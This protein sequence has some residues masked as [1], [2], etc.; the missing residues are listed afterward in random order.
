MPCKRKFRCAQVKATYL[1]PPFHQKT[2]QVLVG[3]Y[4]WCRKQAAANWR[5]LRWWEI[6]FLEQKKAMS[7]KPQT[8][9]HLTQ[10]KTPKSAQN[11]T[12]SQTS[13]FPPCIYQRLGSVQTQAKQ[14]TVFASYIFLKWTWKTKF[15]LQTHFSVTEG[16]LS[17]KC[18]TR[19]RRF[20][21]QLTPGRRFHMGP[22]QAHFAFGLSV[23]TWLA[24]KS[25][26]SSHDSF[27]WVL[28]PPLQLIWEVLWTMF[29][30]H[31]PVARSCIQIQIK[32]ISPADHLNH[33]HTRSVSIS[34]SWSDVPAGW[35]G[36]PRVKQ[37]TKTDPSRARTFIRNKHRLC[38]R[39][40]KDL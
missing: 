40:Q 19:N 2:Q 39:F 25:W 4:K 10:H 9:K 3:K 36:R 37:E 23:S 28:P 20:S 11:K 7:K 34:I 38:L 15:P 24:R 29:N 35:K 13:R 12:R 31:S 30:H 18:D 6:D 8:T 16:S 21:W 22:E 1:S 17:W 14:E 33:F 32:T 5:Y 27:S 26:G